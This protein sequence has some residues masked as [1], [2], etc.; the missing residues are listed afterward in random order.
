[1]VGFSKKQNIFVFGFTFKYQ[2]QN[3]GLNSAI[4]K[5]L[6]LLQPLFPI[7]QIG[8]NTFESETRS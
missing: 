6:P 4:G 5:S 2:V 8:V 7:V 1:M 3:Y